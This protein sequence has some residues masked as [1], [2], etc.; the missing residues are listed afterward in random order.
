M[1]LITDDGEELDISSLQ[2]IVIGETQKVVVTLD[3]DEHIHYSVQVL[4]ETFNSFFG[5]GKW[6]LATGRIKLEVQNG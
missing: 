1:K 5:E 6:L 2:P 3:R 4:V